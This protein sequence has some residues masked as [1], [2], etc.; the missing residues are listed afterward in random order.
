MDKA[1]ELADICVKNDAI[2][3]KEFWKQ[4]D[5]LQ[6]LE[7]LPTLFDIN[8]PTTIRLNRPRI[9]K[10]STCLILAAEYA[11]SFF[12]E[13]LLSR[14]ALR[15]ATDSL[16]DTALLKACKSKMDATKKV[17]AL[18]VNDYE[19]MNK[20]NNNGYT[21]LHCA[22]VNQDSGVLAVVAAHPYVD[23]N[24]VS[25]CGY[26][27]LHVPAS[28]GILPSIEILLSRR[29]ID[30]KVKDQTGHTPLDNA[31]ARG[32]F[33]IFALLKRHTFVGPAD[34]YHGGT[35]VDYLL[36]RAL[37]NACSEDTIQEVKFLKLDCD[38]P[39]SREWG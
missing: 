24:I 38:A 28:Y 4:I 1:T 25:H 39:C 31:V 26:S 17:K 33:K 34:L 14:G 35:T 13:E 23:V 2:R 11:S 10:T 22:A 12:V 36:C 7:L 5:F 37:I 8:R 6:Q 32:N 15:N 27:V 3:F 16:G 21:A 20:Q 18:Q 29:D 9:L 30:I 19:F